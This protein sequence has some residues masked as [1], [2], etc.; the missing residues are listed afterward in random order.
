MNLNMSITCDETVSIV[1][2]S[3]FISSVV[4]MSALFL[5]CFSVTN[6][7]KMNVVVLNVAAPLFCTLILIH[8]F[9]SEMPNMN[10]LF[11]KASERRILK[12]PSPTTGATTFSK[13]TFI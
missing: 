6:V 9:L 10:S 7:V 5:F 2:L 3:V 8:C 1:M 4:R 12:Q 11:K 13:M